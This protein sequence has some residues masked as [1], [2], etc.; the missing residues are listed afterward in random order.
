MNQMTRIT[1]APAEGFSARFTTAEFLR[2]IEADVFGDDKIELIE[3][4]F[5]RM[6]PPGN[7]HAHLQAR[8]VGKLFRIVAE[9]LV[10]G[11][12]GVELEEGTLVG[13]DAGVLRAP[14]T[15][16]RMLRPD[17][18][19]LVVEIAETT[20]ARDLGVKRRKYA[21]AGILNYWVVD[22]ARS[23]VHVH[24]EPVDGEYVDIH[25]VRF[26]QP[27]AVPGTDE[28]IVLT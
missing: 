13:V 24:A 7:D 3:G 19:T 18:L 1:A 25:T 5:H 22:S 27:L 14:V 11:E 6:P 23:V 9:E 4:E 26:G 12:A 10:R 21:E 8:V 2:M 28:H 15:G 16:R 17:E 20:L